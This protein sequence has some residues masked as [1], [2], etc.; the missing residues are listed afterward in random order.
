MTVDAIGKILDLLEA[1][2]PGSFS[3]MSEKQRGLKMMLWI[4]E[5]ENDEETLVYTAVRLLMKDNREYA[6]NI[7]NIRE[8]IRVLTTPDELSDGDAWA[9]VSKAC[10]NGLYGAQKEFDK[11]PPEVQQA[12]GSPEQ[13]KAWAAM[14]AETVQSVVAS[15]FRR[16]F[17]VRQAREK[18][19]SA[20]PAKMREMIEG[21]GRYDG[22][23]IA[24]PTKGE[25]T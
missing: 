15:N 17:R 18:E 2:Y 11:L 16:T 13:L 3:K 24:A 21:V 10:A 9:L 12:V 8:K 22:R 5:F 23:Q 19:L 1:E 14:D 25:W 4:R 6:P 20:L 7:G